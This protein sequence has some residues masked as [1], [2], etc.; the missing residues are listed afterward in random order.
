MSY[1]RALAKGI[2]LVA[3]AVATVVASYFVL[4]AVVAVSRGY[5]WKEMDWDGNGRT[6]IREFLESADTD[7]KA[8]AR[9]CNLKLINGPQLHALIQ[10][11]KAA[12]LQAKQ[13]AAPV[14]ATAPPDAAP[15]CPVCES[16]M[17]RRTAKKGAKAG[18]QFWGCSSFPACRGTR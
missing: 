9:G 15:H 18:S 8:F 7:A 1:V 2:L 11:G 4:L 12:G 3:A 13:P 10:Q 14:R 16:A 17:V 6:S 5:S